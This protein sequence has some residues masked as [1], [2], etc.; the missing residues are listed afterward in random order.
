MWLGPSPLR[1]VVGCRLLRCYIALLFHVGGGR[2]VK[3]YHPP[4]RKK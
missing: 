1:S 4:H 2:R 3:L